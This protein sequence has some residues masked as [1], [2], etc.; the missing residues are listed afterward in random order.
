MLEFEKAEIKNL[1]GPA[2]F[3]LDP[4]VDI[5]GYWYAG[6]LAPAKPLWTFFEQGNKLWNW[7]D[8]SWNRFKMD[9]NTLWGRVWE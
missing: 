6:N 3:V 4:K 2:A 5:R 8:G 9:P 1:D 7:F